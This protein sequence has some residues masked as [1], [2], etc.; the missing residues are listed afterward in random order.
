MVFSC[1]PQQS[2]VQEKQRTDISFINNRNIDCKILK[3]ACDSCFPI[4]DIGYRVR[5]KLSNKEDSLIR[6]IKKELW[7]QLLQKQ[8]TDYAA[9]ALL[10]QLYE[11]DAIV[12]LHHRDIEDWRLSMKYDD[13]TYWKEHIGFVNINAK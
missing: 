12:L 3:I 8:T 9:N 5:I 11:R 13:L 2:A 4:H 7:I 1:T 6:T 10:Y